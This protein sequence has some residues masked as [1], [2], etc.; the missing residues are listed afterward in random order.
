MKSS[1]SSNQLLNGYVENNAGFNYQTINTNH[2]TVYIYN[3]HDATWVNNGIW[4]VI[5]DNNS[6]SYHQIINIVNSM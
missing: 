1:M 6:L 3:G 2:K 5:Q 4:Y